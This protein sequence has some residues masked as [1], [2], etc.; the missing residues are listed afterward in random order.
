[1]HAPQLVPHRDGTLLPG[2]ELAVI[3]GFHQGD[4]KSVRIF[5]GQGG[6]PEAAFDGTLVYFVL[7]KPLLP[8]GQ[9]ARRDGKRGFHR[10]ADSRPAG[11]HIGPGEEG[12]VGAGIADPVGVE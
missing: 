1:M 4:G 2:L 3:A 9:A 5:E 7:R 8:V 11:F 10:Q 12:K 6:F